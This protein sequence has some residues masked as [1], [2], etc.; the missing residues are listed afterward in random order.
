MS[1]LPA[2]CSDQVHEQREAVSPISSLVPT[3]EVKTRPKVD[4]QQSAPDPVNCMTDPSAPERWRARCL[5]RSPGPAHDVPTLRGARRAALSP[6]QVFSVR[7]HENSRVSGQSHP[8][9]LRRAGAARAKWS[10]T[11]PTPATS[12]RGSAAAP[13]SSRRRSTPAGAARAAASRSP[14]RPT[15]RPKRRP[16][17]HRHDAGHPPD[18]PGRAEGRPRCSSSKGCRSRASSTSASSSTAPTEQAGADGQPRRRHG[19]REGRRGDAR[20]H[21]QG[22]HP[23]RRRPAAV[24]GAQA[25]VRARSR[26]R[27][28]RPG[29]RS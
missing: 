13:S 29:G 5:I 20:A 25:G 2:R 26:R 12:P 14:S 4:M 22:V 18:R 3:D 19:D 7:T 8:R 24:P 17:M 27:A 15:R 21:L 16:Q 6:I 11:P 1:R 28:G 23:A 10:S 9:A